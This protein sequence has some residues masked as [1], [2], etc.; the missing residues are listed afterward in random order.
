MVCHTLSH[1]LV[2]EGDTE[3]LPSNDFLSQI[4]KLFLINRFCENI[5]KLFFCVNGL[6]DNCLV[7]YKLSEV[8]VLQSYVF[9]SRSELGT[10]SNFDATVIV[11][12]GCALDFRGAR[13][14]WQEGGNFLHGVHKW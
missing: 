3:R 4:C 5:S 10:L 7:G 8:M 2:N 11:F 13:L 14:D 12:P 1:S 9:C 6:D